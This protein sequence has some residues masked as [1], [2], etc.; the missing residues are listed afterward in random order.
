MKFKNILISSVLIL[1]V[2]FSNKTYANHESPSE[3][4]INSDAELITKN[5]AYVFCSEF[6]PIE[7]LELLLQKHFDVN[8]IKK[9]SIFRRLTRITIRETTLLALP[10]IA[11]PITYAYID[12]LSEIEE[13]YELNFST[14]LTTITNIPSSISKEPFLLLALIPSAIISYILLKSFY[15]ISKVG[16]NSTSNLKLLTEI[17]KMWE[18]YKAHIPE[19]LHQILDLLYSQYLKNKKLN[20]DEYTAQN[21][22]NEILKISLNKIKLNSTAVTA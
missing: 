3:I 18:F 16:T 11:I 13:P 21:I 4:K 22:I 15:A 14:L 12:Y 1:I 20:V 9:E 8:K 7:S 2:I 6:N 17:I 19:E 10:L 5:E